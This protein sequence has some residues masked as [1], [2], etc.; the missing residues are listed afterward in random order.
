M[1]LPDRIKRFRRKA[2]PLKKNDF[3][4]PLSLAVYQ[5]GD[6]LRSPYGLGLLTRQRCTVHP[7]ESLWGAPMPTRT[8]TPAYPAS[9]LL[10]GRPMIITV[11][12]KGLW[13]TTFPMQPTCSIFENV[14]P[15]KSKFHSHALH[16]PH[17]CCPNS[18]CA[19]RR[20]PLRL[21]PWYAP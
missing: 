4:E 13:T 8:Y 15:V 17:S 2:S 19:G 21:P 7:S 10:A 9:N 11:A 5:L 6:H 1:V 14:K 16:L 20:K 12:Q 3:L 18:L